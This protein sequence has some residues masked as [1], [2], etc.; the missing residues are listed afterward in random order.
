MAVIEKYH[1]AEINYFAFI[2]SDTTRL[3]RL[4]MLLTTQIVL[5]DGAKCR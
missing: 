3:S 1:A 4:E 5:D 2:G